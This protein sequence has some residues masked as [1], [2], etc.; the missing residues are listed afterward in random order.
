MYSYFSLKCLSSLVCLLPYCSLKSES[1][2]C[3]RDRVYVFL[4]EVPKLACLYVKRMNVLFPQDDNYPT[5]EKRF[6]VSGQIN[7]A[8]TV[9][10]ITIYLTQQYHK[11]TYS[12]VSNIKINTDTVNCK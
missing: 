11:I 3:P 9:Y 10:Q 4:P 7:T 8:C 5:D 2:L 1:S 12:V 6:P